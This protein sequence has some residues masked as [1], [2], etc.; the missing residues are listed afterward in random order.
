[1]SKSQPAIVTSSLVSQHLPK[2]EFLTNRDTCW[3]YSR[4]QS[5]QPIAEECPALAILH[6][7]TGRGSAGQ[8]RQ[9]HSTVLC[10]FG[11]LGL[12]S[13]A[14]I[15]PERCSSTWNLCLWVD[16]GLHGKQITA[17]DATD[18]TTG[19]WRDSGNTMTDASVDWMLRCNMVLELRHTSDQTV[20]HFR[21]AHDRQI[22]DRRWEMLS[23]PCTDSVDTAYCCV[24]PLERCSSY[25]LVSADSKEDTSSVVA[26]CD[27]AS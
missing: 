19:S 14:L 4:R 10:N 27:Q 9:Q 7:Q 3:A 16:S 22:D 26:D 13:G 12:F 18:L 21:V 15:G 1:M 11:L 6:A 24:S 5:K 2:H 20:V 17:V 23:S 8:S 25:S